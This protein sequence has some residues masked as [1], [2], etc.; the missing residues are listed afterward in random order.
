MSKMEMWEGDTK[1]MAILK[2]FERLDTY[3]QEIIGHHKA[4]NKLT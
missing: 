3:R 4:Y 1:S 2:Q